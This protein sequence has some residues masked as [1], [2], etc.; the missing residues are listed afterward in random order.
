MDTRAF[1]N[2]L[3]HFATGVTIVTARGAAGECVGA[4]VSSF[5]SVSLDPPLV[6]WSLDKRAHSR[7][8]FESSSHFAVHVLTLEQREL[9]ERFANRGVD[10]FEALECRPGLGK[11]PLLPDCAACFECVTRHK[12]DGGDHVIFVGEVERFEHLAGSPLLFHGGAFAQTRALVRDAPPTAL[13]DETTG[14]FGSDFI[15]YLLT[16]AHF[17]VYRPLAREFERAAVTETEYFVLSMLCIAEQLLYTILVSMLEHTGHAPRREDI[18]T[19]TAK[20]YITVQGDADPVITISDAGRRA[21]V[22]LLAVDG[23]IA[24]GALGGFTAQE[25]AEFAG[26]LKRVIANTNSG[27]PDVWTHPE[28]MAKDGSATVCRNE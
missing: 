24:H 2:A 19:L 26:Y 1:R 4:T 8:A 7:A 23:R 15:C 17:Q 11:A 6:L 18:A 25:I 14:R 10:K 9:A 22:L 16:R 5:I 20:G 27:S 13:V 3:G 21:Y 12:Y 28:I